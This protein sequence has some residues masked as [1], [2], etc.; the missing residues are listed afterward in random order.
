[1]NNVV[2]SSLL[3]NIV[4]TMMNNIVGATMLLMHD[5]VVQATTVYNVLVKLLIFHVSFFNM[6]F[7]I[8][9]I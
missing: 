2:A 3:N 8:E 6:D 7:N 4:E 9:T 1:M 5:N